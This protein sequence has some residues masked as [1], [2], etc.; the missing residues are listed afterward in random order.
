[1]WNDKCPGDPA[2]QCCQNSLV[3]LSEFNKM[4]V[5]SLLWAS[6]PFWKMT[7]VVVI[8]NE[9]ALNP[10]GILQLKQQLARLCYRRAVLLSLAEHA[11]KSQL[12]DRTGCEFR[13]AFGCETIHPRCNPRMELGQYS[14]CFVSSCSRRCYSSRVSAGRVDLLANAFLLRSGRSCQHTKL[15]ASSVR[16]CPLYFTICG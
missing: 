14:Q 4:P 8:R 2:V 7:D 12:G 16:L 3:G 10:L 1:L 6:D 13:N 15:A 11:H 9:G 5:S